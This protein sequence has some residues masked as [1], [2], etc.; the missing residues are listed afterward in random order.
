MGSNTIAYLSCAAQLNGE[1]F[2]FGGSESD[3]IKQVRLLQVTMIILIEI[4]I[5][6]I[7]DC[8]LQRIAE[9]PNEFY[10]GACGTFEFATEERVMFCF[11]ESG[12]KTCF[13]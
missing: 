13:R 4:K 11:P 7:T 1:M 10:G 12:K 2:V 6:K 5:S 3:E 8:A 9:L